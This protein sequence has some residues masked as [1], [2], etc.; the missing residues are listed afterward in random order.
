MNDHT[1]NFLCGTTSLLSRRTLLAAG[2]S[3]VASGSGWAAADPRREIVLG[4]VSLSFY[5]VTGA[6]V[7]EVLERLG[8]SV[9]VRQGP[10]EALYPLLGDSTIDLMAAAWLP[11][12]HATYWARYGTRAEEVA[13]LYSGARF[14][15]VFLTMCPKATSNRS[16]IC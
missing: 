8:H 10:H 7:Q 3:V 1:D 15:W 12:G 14:F 13:T 6:I 5:A 11:E 16:A 2:A 4:Q 9:V